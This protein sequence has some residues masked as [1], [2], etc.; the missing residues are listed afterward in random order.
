M[1]A[2]SIRD[3][4]GVLTDDQYVVL[5]STR[6]LGMGDC[7]GMLTLNRMNRHLDS[8]GRSE[9]SKRYHQENRPYRITLK[10]CTISPTGIFEHLADSHQKQSCLMKSNPNP[11]AKQPIDMTVGLSEATV[12]LIFFV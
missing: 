6:Y 9:K 8:T 4:R 3:V 5:S 2:N 10:P 1:Y 7:R 12:L 11:A